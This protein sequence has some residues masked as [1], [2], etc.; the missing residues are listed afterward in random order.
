MKKRAKNGGGQGKW[1]VDNSSMMSDDGGTIVSTVGWV[2]YLYQNR[3]DIC[4]KALN[5][6]T[7]H[8]FDY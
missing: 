1:T 4:A 5:Y 7:I 6:L 3:F 2:S 8:I